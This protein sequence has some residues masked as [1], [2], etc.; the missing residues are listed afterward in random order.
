MQWQFLFRRTVS[1]MG[2]KCENVASCVKFPLHT[3]YV[4]N[5][6]KN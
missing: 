4:G 5:K 3:H 2:K 6:F 1:V